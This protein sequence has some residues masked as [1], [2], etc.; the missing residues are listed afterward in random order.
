[1]SQITKSGA[2]VTVEDLI[3]RKDELFGTAPRE[4]GYL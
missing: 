1:V 3:A 4:P 2:A